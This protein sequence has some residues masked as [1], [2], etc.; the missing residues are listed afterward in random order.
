MTNAL[1]TFS[2]KVDAEIAAPL[3]E[4]AVG[5]QLVA[6][7]VAADFGIT[8]VDWATL[9]EMSEAMV[10]YNFSD[11]NQDTV[12]FNITNSKVPIFWKDYKLDRRLMMAMQKAGTN[13][14]VDAALSAAYRV[15]SAENTA[16]IQGISLDGTNYK[17]NGLY[18]GAGNDYS[19]QKDFGTYGN[20]IAAVGG[21]LALIAADGGPA[22]SIP[23]NL[24]LNPT[25]YAELLISESTSGVSEYDRVKAILKGGEIFSSTAITAGTGLLS[26]ASAQGK[27]FVDYYLTQDVIT[28]HGE[29]SKHPDTGPIYGRVFTAGV[30]RIKQANALAK[31]SVI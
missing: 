13:V 8:S 6:T 19:T 14:D 1:R 24:A 7:T 10:T 16:I 25:Q 23:Y 2:K 21:G 27:P 29:D 28:E 5:R 20:A 31:L 4:V 18:Q 30:L 11:G 26:P 17:V 3:R 12:D 15:Q 22:Y 9:T